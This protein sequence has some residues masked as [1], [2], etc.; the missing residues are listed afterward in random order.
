MQFY[1]MFTSITG[2]AGLSIPSVLDNNTGAADAIFPITL[3]YYS[4]SNSIR[5]KLN[6]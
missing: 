6:T 4:K 3:Y 2:A 5:T 1:L